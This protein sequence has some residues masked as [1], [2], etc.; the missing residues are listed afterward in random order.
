MRDYILLRTKW[1]GEIVQKDSKERIPEDELKLFTIN[2]PSATLRKEL[3]KL[4]NIQL[5]KAD[6]QRIIIYTKKRKP[7][8]D[9][10]TENEHYDFYIERPSLEKMF[11][12]SYE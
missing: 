8:I 5:E 2:K 1:R 9:I 12:K 3:E 11:I 10:L 4:S 7:I 6:G